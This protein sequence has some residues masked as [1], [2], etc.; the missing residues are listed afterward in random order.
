MARNKRTTLPI[1][2]GS[3][4]LTQRGLPMRRLTMILRHAIVGAAT[5]RPQ[6]HVL[7]RESVRGDLLGTGGASPAPT[8]AHSLFKD[9]RQVKGFPV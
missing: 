6:T 2:S 9:C 3:P 7:R 8:M 4:S 1:P 5:C